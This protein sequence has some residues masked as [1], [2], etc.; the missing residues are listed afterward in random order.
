VSAELG[1]A[2]CWRLLGTSNRSEMA[3]IFEPTIARVMGLI[4]KQYNVAAGTGTVSK[5]NVCSRRFGERIFLL[6]HFLTYARSNSCSLADSQDPHT[7]NRGSETGAS[8]KASSFRVLEIILGTMPRSLWGEHHLTDIAGE[9]W[10]K[11]PQC[12]DLSL[13]TRTCDYLGFTAA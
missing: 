7:S 2:L 9:P 1:F 13:S 12:E 10:L 6:G 8:S 4:T 11:E 5:I 3:T